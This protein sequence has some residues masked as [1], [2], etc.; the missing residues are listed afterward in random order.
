MRAIPCYLLYLASAFCFLAAFA[1]LLF[2]TFF[3]MAVSGSEYHEIQTNDR[4]KAYSSLKFDSWQTGQ[5][6]LQPSSIVNLPPDCLIT[7]YRIGSDTNLLCAFTYYEAEYRLPDGSTRIAHAQGPMA[8]F[9]VRKAIVSGA[10]VLFPTFGIF[11]LVAAARIRKAIGTTS[12]SL[13]KASEP[14]H[15]AEWR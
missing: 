12:D 9:T 1:P 7:R 5:G 10:F 15:A 8:M 4:P 6:Q 2:G 13:R 3:A 11:L 14:S